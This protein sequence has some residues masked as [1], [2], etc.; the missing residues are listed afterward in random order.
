MQNSK[1][2]FDLSIKSNTFYSKF[3]RKIDKVKYSW[4][5]FCL[6]ERVW[7][8]LSNFRENFME[9][10]RITHSTQKWWLATLTLLFASPPPFFSYKKCE[11]PSRLILRVGSS[12]TLKLAP[13][14]HLGHKKIHLFLL[15]VKGDWPGR[16]RD[17]RWWIKSWN[18]SR[19]QVLFFSLSV[20]YISAKPQGV[21]QNFFPRASF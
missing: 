12:F 7:L 15:F 9:P 13:P 5:F 6:V 21:H 14:P 19:E 3:A 20:L 11:F 18:S 4:L 17:W 10:A 16:K 2:L 1:C 8:F